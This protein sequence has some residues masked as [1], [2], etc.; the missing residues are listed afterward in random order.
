[1][2]TNGTVDPATL[3][4]VESPSQRLTEHRPYTH[5]YGVSAT[6]PVDQDRVES[7][8]A[9]DSVLTHEV[10]SHVAGLA[11]RPGM[12]DGRVVRSAVLVSCQ[13]P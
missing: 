7:T 11:F 1:V 9:Y 10:V 2:G 3:R 6:A 13:S 4:V 5:V 8:V 12:R